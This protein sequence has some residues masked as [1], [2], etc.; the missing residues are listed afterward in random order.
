MEFR[1]IYITCKDEAEARG[2]GRTLVDER[3]AACVN[4]FPIQSIFR[5]KG[6]IEEAGEVVETVRGVGYRFSLP[7]R[8]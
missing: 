2:I 4:F 8:E 6:R 1:S 5:W 7:Q 3:L